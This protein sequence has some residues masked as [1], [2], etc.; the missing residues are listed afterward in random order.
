MAMSLLLQ[1]SF[2][3]G[4]IFPTLTSRK[5]LESKCL[6]NTAISLDVFS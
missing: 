4:R 1:G 6:S 2:L 3:L 5:Y